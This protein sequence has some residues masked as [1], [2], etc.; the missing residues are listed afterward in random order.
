MK[1][2]WP[3]NLTLDKIKYEF[4]KPFLPPPKTYFGSDEEWAWAT[5]PA[6]NFVAP[7]H[8]L[9]TTPNVNRKCVLNVFFEYFNYIILFLIKFL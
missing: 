4:S 8:N 1:V 6:P 2:E 7:H 3:E 9:L 5:V